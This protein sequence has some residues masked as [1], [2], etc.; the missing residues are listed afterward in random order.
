[1]YN[2][3]SQLPL[4]AHCAQA[5]LSLLSSTGQG[6]LGVP[7]VSLTPVVSSAAAQPIE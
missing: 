6:A 5:T 3:K 4:G 2:G 1:V 7:P